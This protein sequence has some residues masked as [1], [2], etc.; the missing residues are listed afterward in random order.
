M[1]ATDHVQ[2]EPAASNVRGAAYPAVH[3]DLRVTFR[4]EAPTAH[5]VQL[6]TGGGESG[7]GAGPYD[8]LREDGGAWTVTIP[9]AV[10]GLHYYWLLVDG[11][12][13]NDPGSQTYF[14]YG[15]PTSAVEVPEPGVDF[16]TLQHVPHGEVRRR[17]YFAQTTGA[18]RHVQVY[19]PPD[20]D[21]DQGKRYPVLYLQHGAGEDETGWSRQG[22]ANIILDNLIAAGQAEPMLVVMDCGYAF[23]VPAGGLMSPDVRARI[24][25]AFGELLL[26]DVIPLIDATYRTYADREHRALA[27]LSMGGM[28]ALS[29]GLT[30]LDTFAT[31][32]A[33]SAARLD[34]FDPNT[35]Y[36][37]V[38]ADAEAFNR[39]T[40]LFWLSAGTAEQR[41]HEGLQEFDAT[42]NEL[43]ITHQVFYSEGTAHEWQTWR[44]SLY[45]F[46]PLLFRSTQD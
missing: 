41:F 9:P 14:G 42:L 18:W 6:A 35:S 23:D 8:M 34:T 7:L 5:S 15:K 25:S 26:S 44:R 36:G 37:G 3:P 10:P 32:G 20:Y 30:H 21:Q 38:L 46:A 13:A 39:R 2:G 27:G 16:Y 33:F 17:P 43:G 11:V 22:R 1:T 29:I 12:Q 45:H 28:Q 31:V 19:T 40:Q 4:V 24:S